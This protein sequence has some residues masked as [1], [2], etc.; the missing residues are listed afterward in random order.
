MIG[1]VLHR[2]HMSQ[3][4]DEVYVATCDS[5]I[6]D[7]VL[8]IGGKAVM[9]ADT[10]E[11]CTDRT[12]EALVHI[13][14]TLGKQF[15]IVVMIQGDEP[16]LH[17]SMI[18]EALQPMLKDE[19]VLVTNL[20]APLK[21]EKEHN[22]PNEVKVVMDLEMNALYFSREPIPSRKKTLAPIPMYKQV[23]VIP[24]RRDF[25][26]QFNKMPPSPLEIIESV[27]M[28]RILEHGFRIKMVH[29]A[30]DVY[31][32]DTEEDRQLVESLLAHDPIINQY[33]P[34]A[35]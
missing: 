31:S 17:P 35:R 7:Y 6:Y 4:L 19:S 13:E 33:F 12:A 23:C 11:R 14:R 25:L 28:L 32:V 1:H 16:M 34:A 5:S 15:D 27:D 20:V 10:H 8:S 21:N 30:H 3:I 22:N 18:D 9:T 26:F 24:F 29:T 2:S